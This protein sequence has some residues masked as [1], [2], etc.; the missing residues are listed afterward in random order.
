M[1]LFVG[2]ELYLCDLD[3]L[4]LLLGCCE[5]GRGGAGRHVSQVP[6]EAQVV[7]QG[8]QTNRML[9]SHTELNIY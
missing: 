1:I 3:S 2:F 7:L 5:R 6:L 9:L 4:Q 8:G